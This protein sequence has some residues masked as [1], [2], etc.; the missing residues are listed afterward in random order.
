[1]SC[2][3]RR[4]GG[5]GGGGKAMSSTPTINSHAFFAQFHGHPIDDLH[6]AYYHFRDGSD[7]SNGGEIFWLAGDSSLDNKYWFADSG[8]ACN[9]WEE[10]LRPATARKDVAFALN[11]EILARGKQMR[12]INCSVEATSVGDRACG[13]LQ[14]QDQMIRD[15][16][17]PQDTLCVSIGGNDIALK[18]NLCTILNMILLMQCLPQW[19][20]ERT[21]CGCDVP[22]DDCFCGFACGCF[23]N[24]L[25]CPP[26][27]GYFLHL[28]KTRIQAYVEHL[29]SKTKPKRVLVA[30]IYYPDELAGG[31]W[32][33]SS[34]SALGYNSNPAKL[35]ALIRLMFERATREIKIEGTEVVAVPLFAVLDG[36]TTSDYC[37]R[38]EP[39]AKGGVKMAKLLLDAADDD[40]GRRAMDR[41]LGLTGAMER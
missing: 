15:H 18:P 32:A 27:A 1:M 26:G 2:P 20:I 17:A 11:K 12:V 31:S 7:K 5:G 34:L 19:C 14:E 9:G 22:V 35:Q 13:R 21:A 30:M 24:L 39:S 38:V 4:T 40:G 29:V 3:A 25:A 16:I 28:F 6:K 10:L 36:K 37:S 41:A 23:S 8:S 33:D